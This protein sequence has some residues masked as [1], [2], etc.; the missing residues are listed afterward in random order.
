MGPLK[1]RL[2]GLFERQF[3]LYRKDGWPADSASDYRPIGL[4]DEAGK[5]LERAGGN[6]AI[7]TRIVR[8]LTAMGPD[9]SPSQFGCRAGRSTLDALDILKGFAAIAAVGAGWRWRFR[10]ISP[11]RSTSA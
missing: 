9:L 2:R 3:I 11:T 10:S 7:A 5:L 4:R 8:H 1:D 6:D